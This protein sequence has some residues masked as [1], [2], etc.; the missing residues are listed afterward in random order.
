MR[1]RRMYVI[2][3]ILLVIMMLC[4]ATFTYAYFTAP[5]SES[6]SEY[7]ITSTKTGFAYAESGSEIDLL[8]SGDVMQE[9]LQNNNVAAATAVNDDPI[10]VTLNTSVNGGTLTCTYDIYYIPDTPFMNSIENTTNEKEFTIKGV[11]DKGSF[12]TEINLG[13]VTEKI[14]LAENVNI[15]LSGVS[16]VLVQS[17]TFT[18]SFYN[19]TFVQ[20]DNAGKEFGGRIV[21][22][23]LDCENT[24]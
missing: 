18:A 10:T 11:S 16:K 5:S 22:E 23:D 2:P 20:D 17:W 8:V 12:A 6:Y 21:L 9:P 24:F 4:T 7:D 19:Q 1:Q 13:N 3:T 14:M 15:A